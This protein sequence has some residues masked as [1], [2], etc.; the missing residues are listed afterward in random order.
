MY[1]NALIPVHEEAGP[2]DWQECGANGN[3]KRQWV[4]FSESLTDYTFYCGEVDGDGKYNGIGI[5]INS[6]GT[7]Y[8]GMWKANK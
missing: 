7:I 1:I 4:D 6:G 8:E 3:K 5:R 2:Y